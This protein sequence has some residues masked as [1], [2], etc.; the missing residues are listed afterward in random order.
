MVPFSFRLLMNLVGPGI[1][2]ILSKTVVDARRSPFALRSLAFFFSRD[3]GKE[4]R[5]DT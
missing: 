4:I 1:R 3:V 2:L 5:R